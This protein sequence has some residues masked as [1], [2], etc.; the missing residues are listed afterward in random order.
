MNT[1]NHYFIPDIIVYLDEKL[2]KDT[3]VDLIST[4]KNCQTSKNFFLNW[5]SINLKQLKMIS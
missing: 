3:L 5:Y 1:T 2:D 4:C